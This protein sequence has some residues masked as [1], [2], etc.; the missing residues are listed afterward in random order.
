MLEI[1]EHIEI[2][3]LSNN[4]EYYIFTN[5]KLWGDVNNKVD[6]G[7]KKKRNRNHEWR[8]L[9]SDEKKFSDCW[10]SAGVYF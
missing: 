8:N 3:D 9:L 1:K 7:N 6:N 2:M 4:N 5:D 10:G